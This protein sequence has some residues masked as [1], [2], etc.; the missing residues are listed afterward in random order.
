MNERVEAGRLVTLHYRIVLDSGET[1]IST[2]DGP[3]ATLQLGAGELL[4]AL[5]SKLAGLANGA[6]ERFELAPGEAFGQ[7]HPERVENVPQQVFGERLPEAGEVVELEGPDRIRLSGQ[8]LTV[9]D[10]GVTIDFNHP[11]AGKAIEFEV[12]IL[13]V[14]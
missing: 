9:A 3:P 4:P 10:E 7:H 11:L 2:F 12:R 8:V 1:V 13:D 14:M 5:E 6:H